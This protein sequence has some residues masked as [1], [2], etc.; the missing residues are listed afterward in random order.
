MS[1]CNTGCCSSCCDICLPEG[2]CNGGA[3]C[4]SCC[5]CPPP[6][7]GTCGTTQCNPPLLSGETCLNATYYYYG[8]LTSGSSTGNVY[9]TFNFQDVIFVPG[10][11]GYPSMNSSIQTFMLDFFANCG[12]SSMTG[13]TFGTTP[14][15][16][17]YVFVASGIANYSFMWQS[18]VNYIVPNP[19]TVFTGYGISGCNSSYPTTLPCSS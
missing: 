1:T 7:A 10:G 13:V 4:T 12:I 6:A 3:C 5:P 18:L 15:P 16:S 17:N 9:Y 19:L 2:Y 11:Y 14:P 8:K